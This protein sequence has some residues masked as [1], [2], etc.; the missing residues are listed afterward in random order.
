MDTDETQVSVELGPVAVICR[1]FV[2]RVIEVWAA[3]ERRSTVI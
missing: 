3:R 2:S 1:T